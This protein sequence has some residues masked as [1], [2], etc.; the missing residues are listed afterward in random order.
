MH[1]VPFE[2]NSDYFDFDTDLVIQFLDTQKRIEEIPIP[3]FYGDE[4]SRVNGIR[5]AIRVVRSCILSRAI[6]LGVYYHPKFDYEHDLN[7]HYK[8][9]F[10]YASSQQFALDQVR[11]GATVLDIGCGPGFMARRL[12]SKKVKTVSID[13]QIQP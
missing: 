12:A 5:Y 13:R 1:L 2:R 8:E 9:K 10:G 11:A 7:T 4:V 3:T 6:R